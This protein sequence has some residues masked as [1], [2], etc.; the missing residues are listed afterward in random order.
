MMAHTRG[1]VRRTDNLFQHLLAP[2]TAVNVVAFRLL[3]L[4]PGSV[5][6]Q[7]KYEVRAVAFRPLT[8]C[9]PGATFDGNLEDSPVS[10]AVTMRC[11]T[12]F[13][14]WHASSVRRGPSSACRQL[15]LVK[16]TGESPPPDHFSYSSCSCLCSNQ[17]SWG[18][19]SMRV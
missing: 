1:N 6:L 18:E 7:G 5:V 3:G 15:S 2:A 9:M 19:V 13:W 14:P 16:E 10:E 11:A 17:H 8:T 4:L 12:F